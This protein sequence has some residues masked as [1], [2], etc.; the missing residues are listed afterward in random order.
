MEHLISSMDLSKKDIKEIFKIADDFNNGIF[1]FVDSG[2]TLALL[3]ERPSTRTRVSFEAAMIKLGGSAIY[4][5]S[6]TSQISRGESI[7]DTA[8]VLSSYVDMIA[9]RMQKHSD[10]VELAENSSIPVINALTDMEHPCQA[11][12]DIYTIKQVKG[13]I[14]GLRIAFVG[15]IAANTANSLM[16]TA[17]LAGAEISLVGP[18]KPNAEYLKR[19]RADGHVS[20]YSNI[21]EG[22]RGA[23][24]VY[25]DTFVSMGKEKEAG[26]R[27]RAFAGYQ[28]NRKLVSYA[29][30]DAII[31]HCLPAHRGEEITSDIIDGKQSVVW[32]QA[33]NKMLIEKAIILHLYKQ[34]RIG[35]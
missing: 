5:D 24:V 31:M 10:I 22:I 32:E 4:I 7:G 9:A 28:V 17:S 8:R 33:R 21:I 34:R 15:D 19:A 23:D 35:F 11:L 26:Q 30:K 18:N 13:A 1:S 25:T 27:R 16:V 2:T 14:E 12:S 29:K 6:A 3:F 20:V